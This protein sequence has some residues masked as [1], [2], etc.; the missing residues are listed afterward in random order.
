MKGFSFTEGAET[1]LMSPNNNSIHERPAPLGDDIVRTA[2]K[3]A[4]FKGK[5]LRDN[6][7]E[8][9]LSWLCKL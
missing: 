5:L 2:G 8:A 9:R 7:L 4:E 6:I 1:R 3:L